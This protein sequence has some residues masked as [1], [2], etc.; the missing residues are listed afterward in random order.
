MKLLIRSLFTLAV[1]LSLGQAEAQNLAPDQNPNFAVSRDK[2]MR[3]ADSVN[4]WHSTT[5]QETYSAPDWVERREQRQQERRQFRRD[6]RLERQ[7][8][9]YQ[10]YHYQPYGYSPYGYGYPNFRFRRFWW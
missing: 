4:R 9:W 1:L 3:L 5:F 2:Y 10:P 7:R 8:R 6:L